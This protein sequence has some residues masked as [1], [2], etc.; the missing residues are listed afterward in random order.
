MLLDSSSSHC[1]IDYSVIF[2][3]NL[4]TNSIL[5]ILLCLFDGTSN[6]AITSIMTILVTFSS[7]LKMLVTFYITK[8]DNP[9]STA[10]G[11]IKFQNCADTSETSS[12]LVPLSLQRNL[13]TPPSTLAATSHTASLI[14]LIGAAAFT[15]VHCLPRTEVFSLHFCAVKSNSLNALDSSS[16]PEKYHKF[17]NVF[18]DVKANT[19]AEHRPFDLKIELEKGQTP[20]PSHMYSLLQLKLKAL[21]EFLK[22]NMSNGFI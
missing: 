6:T 9:I 20:S 21:Q 12:T 5:P 18:S 2:E 14:A 8:L 17:A 19:L 7:D 16:I 10:S 22:E 11:C 15:I 1:F 13:A 3:H 4:L